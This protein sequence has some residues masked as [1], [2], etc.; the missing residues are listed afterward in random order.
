MV[1]GLRV[2]RNNAYS[3]ISHRHWNTGGNKSQK[4]NTG[5]PTH[6]VSVMVNLCDNYCLFHMLSKYKF[7]K[8]KLIRISFRCSDIDDVKASMLHAFDMCM[9][10]KVGKEA[11]LWIR[12]NQLPHLTLD[13]IWESDKYTKTLNT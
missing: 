11:K 12:Y 7:L 3:D 5:E 1:Q 4:L 10:C 8:I 9:Q 6:R 13:T 2:N